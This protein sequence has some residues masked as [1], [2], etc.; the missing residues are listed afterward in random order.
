MNT[1]IMAI[2]LIKINN[3]IR[4]VF[5]FIYQKNYIN[6]ILFLKEKLFNFFK[7]LTEKYN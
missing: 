3:S 4:N 5:I 6:I 2:L 1:K 7:Y